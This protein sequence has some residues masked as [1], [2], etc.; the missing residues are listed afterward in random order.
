[1]DRLITIIL[2]AAGAMLLPLSSSAL[3]R[4]IGRDIEFPKNY[5]PIKAAALRH[6]IQS[7]NYQFVGGIVSYWEPD[8][9]TRLS[10]D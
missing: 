10:F 5:D 1:M 2:F 4:S 9:S 8:Y 3:S 6:V 7:T